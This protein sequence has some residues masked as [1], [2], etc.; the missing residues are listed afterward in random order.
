MAADASPIQGASAAE[1]T[2]F[3]MYKIGP[4]FNNCLHNIGVKKWYSMYI[5]TDVSWK[6]FTT[7]G[8]GVT[9]YGIVALDHR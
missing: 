4:I 1:S 8:L 5:Y 6:Q 7:L 3:D 9:L 2:V